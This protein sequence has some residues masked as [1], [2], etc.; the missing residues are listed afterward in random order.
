MTFLYDKTTINKRASK[1]Y[2]NISS[3]YNINISFI[4]L[5]LRDYLTI[6]V[7]IKCSI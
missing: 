6:K 1:S 7:Y 3:L 2:Q 5:K 4:L